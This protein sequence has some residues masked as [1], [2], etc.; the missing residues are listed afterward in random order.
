MISQI[1]HIKLL[2]E[3]VEDFIKTEFQLLKL[4][5]V[6]KSADIVSTIYASVVIL[7]VATFFVFLL[8]I[9][10]SMLIGRLLGN[11]ELGFFAMAAFWGIICTVLLL[12]RRKL[13]KEPAENTII[14]KIL[15]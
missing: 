14:K 15:D 13:L 11:L 8:S 4:K 3:N 2:I 12:A 10:L 6:D 7:V 1:T 9:G 5:S